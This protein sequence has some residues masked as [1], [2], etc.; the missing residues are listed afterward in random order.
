VDETVDEGDDTGGVRENLVPFGKGLVG[1]EAAS[2]VEG[3]R[4]HWSDKRQS[5][6]FSVQLEGSYGEW[7]KIDMIVGGTTEEEPP[8]QRR[9]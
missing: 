7:K 3:L 2:A 1:G 6:S 5:D 4:S 8:A 9:E